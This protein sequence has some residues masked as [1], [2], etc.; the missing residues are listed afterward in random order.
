MHP[1]ERIPRGLEKTDLDKW[2]KINHSESNK[3]ISVYLDKLVDS[4]KEM[5]GDD[6]DDRVNRFTAKAQGKVSMPDSPEEERIVSYEL[7]RD[8]LDRI[9]KVFATSLRDALKGE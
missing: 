7:F 3:D 5:L 6:P 9:H 1:A 2:A 8:D 4:F